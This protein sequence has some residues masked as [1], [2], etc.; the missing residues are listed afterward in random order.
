M[1]GAAL[2]AVGAKASAL[3]FMAFTV[4]VAPNALSLCGV[5]CSECVEVFMSAQLLLV[6]IDCSADVLVCL[7]PS[8]AAMEMF[9]FSE[10]ICC[11][12]C[13]SYVSV[14]S[15]MFSLFN[16]SVDIISDVTLDLL[17]LLT[18]RYYLAVSLAAEYSFSGF[19]IP[20]HD[21]AAFLQFVISYIQ[22]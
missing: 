8:A 9:R 6:T 12:G 3:G 21:L 11:I 1:E 18:L 5:V 2:L 17:S 10:L 4:L 14:S 13:F 15:V 20:R 16:I 22:V 7:K 19:S